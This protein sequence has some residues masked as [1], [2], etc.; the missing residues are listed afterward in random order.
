M[1]IH[2]SE[3]AEHCAPEDEEDNIPGEKD[4]YGHV[5][6]D[7]WKNHEDESRGRRERANNGSEDLKD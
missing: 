7:N 2:R 4:R 5:R 6:D 1:N 3:E